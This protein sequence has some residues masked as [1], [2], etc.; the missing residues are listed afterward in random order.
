MLI[1]KLDQLFA[2]E[3]WF[4]IHDNLPSQGFLFMKIVGG[5]TL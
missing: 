1:L 4:I 2:Q 5:N 3:R